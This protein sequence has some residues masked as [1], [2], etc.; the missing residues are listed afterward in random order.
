MKKI[1]SLVLALCLILSAFAMAEGTL[2]M[3]TNAAFPPYEM[4]ADDGSFEG[5]DVEIA[6]AIAKKLGLELQVDDMGFDAALQAAQQGKSDIIM[7]GVTVTEKRLEVMEFSESYSNGVQVIIVKNG[8]EVTLDNMGDYMTL[9]DNGNDGAYGDIYW[10]NPASLYG[11]WGYKSWIERPEVE[12]QVNR[13][14]NR[15]TSTVRHGGVFLLNIGP[16]GNGKV[17]NYEKDVLSGIG[18]FLDAHPDTLNVLSDESK[19]QEKH[20]IVDACK[21]NE[22]ILKTSDGIMHPAIDGTGYMS[23]VADSWLSWNVMVDN[24][25]EYDVFVV[26]IPQQYAKEYIIKTGKECLRSVL[27]GVDDMLQTAYM[28]KIHLQKGEN[29]IIFDQANR[30]TPLDALD[31]KLEKVILRK[32]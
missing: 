9:P 4:V 19:M 15:L 7:A 18:A 27:P 28:G 22:I 1:L 29:E 24:M 20:N 26:Y 21:Q 17:I 16:D 5:I 10:D 25:A 31:M 2:I 6:G 32:R 12:K 13:Q 8:S 23:V 14:L 11:T 30:C 3:G